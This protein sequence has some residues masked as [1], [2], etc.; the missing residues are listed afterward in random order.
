VSDV[1]LAIDCS[2]DIICARRQGREFATQAGFSSSGVMLVGAA[3]SELAR[4]IVLHA[5]RGSI[6][7]ARISAD[8]RA[9]VRII[10]RDDG[11]GIPVV[12]QTAIASAANPHR[13]D[14]GLC[15]IKQLFD[16]FELVSSIDCGTIVTV[17][18]WMS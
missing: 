8:G 15:A 17:E 16:G 3:V 14:L 6:Q 7:L 13:S 12:K 11:P 9:G 1:E 5:R 2:D 4:N 18:K 10:A